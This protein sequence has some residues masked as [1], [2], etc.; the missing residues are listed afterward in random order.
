MMSPIENNNEHCLKTLVIKK[1]F[2][3]KYF[4]KVNKKATRT[5]HVDVVAV[6][7]VLTL[8]RY[9]HI[10]NEHCVNIALLDIEQFFNDVNSAGE[11]D[12]NMLLVSNKALKIF[13][14]QFPLFLAI[15][16][17]GICLLR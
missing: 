10:A 3:N 7:L 14:E 4:F 9:L 11:D 5:I 6:H 17:T 12:H 2:L 16:C 15:F 13:V 1:N 8:N